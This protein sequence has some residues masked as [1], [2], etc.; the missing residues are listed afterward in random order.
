MPL[1]LYAARALPTLKNGYS[2]VRKWNALPP[3]ARAAV[4]E[5]GRR[6][7]VAIMA[8]KVAASAE[9]SAADPPATWQAA[10]ETIRR[11]GPA[12]EMAK[13]VV[14]A[15]QKVPEATVEE[16]ADAV[17]AT[18]KN[19]SILKSAM[20]MA[21]DDGYIRRRGVNLRGIKWDITE[22]ADLNLIDNPQVCRLETEIAAFVGEFGIAS[23]DQIS[24]RLCL[25]DDSPELRSAL[26]RAISD[27]SV[28]WY[29]NGIYGLAQDQL[30]DF[31]PKRD[32]WAETVPAEGRRDFEGALKE[33]EL[34]VKGLAGAL[35]GGDSDDASDGLAP[36]PS[37]SP[38]S[39]GEGGDDP[40]DAIQRL[41][42][43]REKGVLTEEEFAAKK[44]ELLQRI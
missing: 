38:G 8:V 30:E 10:R 37:P 14:A 31:E 39:G 26:E 29:C 43:L 35:K 20:R 41:Q 16:I 32:L 11:A 42:E 7:V 44:A 1:V 12:E 36:T 28:H 21:Q 15:L 24:S 13:A 18:G 33:L 9:R 40:Y 2:L 22:W 27:E 5:Q 23:L 19:D 4:Q 17:G 25:E 6:T 34:A 3:E